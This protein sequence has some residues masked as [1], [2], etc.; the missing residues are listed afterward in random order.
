M[1]VAVV[2]GAGSTAMLVRPAGAHTVWGAALGAAAGPALATG[3]LRSCRRSFVRHDYP[4]IVTPQGVV[5]SG[6]LLWVAQ[7]FDVALI[8][9]LPAL[10]AITAGGFAGIA[11]A[12]QA[13]VSI[14]VLT[15]FLT[16]SATRRTR[17]RLGRSARAA[18]TRA[19]T[20]VWRL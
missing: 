8:G 5:P 15:A 4:L 11:V 2:W 20:V 7:A 17:E 9:T 19:V 3:A 16:A 10:T 18:V 6:P 13:V 12:V 1:G 14:V